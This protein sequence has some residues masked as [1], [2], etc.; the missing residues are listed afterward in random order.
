[1]EIL[2]QRHWE[3]MV[4]LIS[5]ESAYIQHSI[6]KIEYKNILLL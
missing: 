5:D 3:C 1:M 2:E 4:S 6:R